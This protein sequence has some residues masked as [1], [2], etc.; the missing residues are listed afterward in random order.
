MKTVKFVQVGAYDPYNTVDAHQ[1]ALTLVRQCCS[2][3]N[4]VA[5][6]SQRDWDFLPGVSADQKMAARFPMP[7]ATM[8]K[9]MEHDYLAHPDFRATTIWVSG[10]EL[11]VPEGAIAYKYADPTEDARWIY[12]DDDLAAIKRSDPSLVL[13]VVAFDR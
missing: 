7:T 8:E 2:P 9:L 3:L 1:Q 11:D 5:Y 10:T 4:P 13:M 6:R 12:E